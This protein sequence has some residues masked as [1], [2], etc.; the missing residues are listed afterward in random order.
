MPSSSL[1]T[2][3]QSLAPQV[4][5]KLQNL[6][7]PFVRNQGQLDSNVAFSA[8]T[9]GG[10]LYVTR[11]GALVLSLPV[12]EG[13]A[14]QP[15]VIRE[16]FMGARVKY[17][18][19]ETPLP[20]KVCYFHG[21]DP[22]KWRRNISTYSA[23]SLGEIYDGV[24]LKLRANA[25]NVEKLFCLR[26]GAKPENI[27]TQ[28]SGAFKT[29]ITSEGLLAMETKHGFVSFSKPVAY[30][31]VDGK[32]HFVNA[33]YRLTKDGYG[34]TI[35]EYDKN[36]ELII[37]PLIRASYLG[38]SYTEYGYNLAVHP[39]SGDVYVIGHTE[40]TDFPDTTGA[41]Q[42]S[43]GGNEDVYV[44]RFNADLTVL[45]QVSYLG[46]TGD[47][48]G[49]ALAFHSNTGDVYLTGSTNSTD[50]PSAV[51][52]N[53]GGRDM[54]IARLSEDL[55]TLQ[56]ALY[57]GTSHNDAGN[58]LV[59]RPD[60]ADPTSGELYIAGYYGRP[61]TGYPDAKVLRFN[62]E[63][64]IEMGDD[65]IGG[66]GN[67]IGYDLA[68]YSGDNPTDLSD[69][70]IYLVGYAGY[71]PSIPDLFV[72][73]FPVTPG[74][75]QTVFGGQED[76]FVARFNNDLTITEAATFLGAAGIDRG[77][78]IEVDTSGPSPTI[79]ITGYLSP[80]DPLPSNLLVFTGGAQ[81]TLAGQQDGFVARFNADLSSL[82]AGSYYG[83]SYHDRAW[84]LQ[85]GT[86]GDAYIAGVAQSN[87]LSGT[88]GGAQPGF[89]GGY[90]D[91]F[92]ARFS[93][94]LSSIEQA[95]Y[96]G[97]SAE[98]ESWWGMVIHPSN[99]DVY[100]AGETVSDD[101]SPTSGAP[102]ASRA[103]SWDGFVAAMD[104]D[105]KGEP[106]ADVS[107]D[108]SGP[109]SLALNDVL[110]Y[111]LTVSNN[112][113]DEATAVKVRDKL[114]EGVS[115]SEVSPGS[116]NVYGP[117][118]VLDQEFDSASLPPG[119]LE[120]H[121][122]VSDESHKAQTFTVDLSGTL[123]EIGVYIY[124]TSSEVSVPLLVDVRATDAQ[125][126]PVEDDNS[127]LA[128]AVVDAVDVPTTPGFLTV[129]ISAANLVVED[130]DLLAI[131]LR[132]NAQDPTTES[133][134]H[135]YGAGSNN[136]YSNGKHFVRTTTYPTWTALED[137]QATVPDTGFNSTVTTSY[138]VVEC[139]LGTLASG[140]STAVVI[141]GTGP[142]VD[143]YMTNEAAV[144]AAE[145]DPDM[146]NNEDSLTTMVGSPEPDIA[147]SPLTY[148]FGSVT[149]GDMTTPQTFTI[150]NNGNWELTV[151]SISNSNPSDFVM[152]VSGGGATCSS[153]IPFV[154][155]VG[156]SCDITVAFAPSMGGTRTANITIGSD[157]PDENPVV[158]T[159]TG[160]GIGEGDID[161]I[162]TSMS[163]PDTEVG[164][165]SELGIGISNTGTVDLTVT[166]IS[167]TEAASPTNF[168]LVVSGGNATCSASLPFTLTASASCILSVTFAPQSEGNHPA[169]VIITSDDPDEGTIYVPISGTGT[170]AGNGGDGG[171]TCFIAT[172]AR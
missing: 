75:A 69:D 48:L 152:V 113:P 170:A 27:R 34:F 61:G 145:F 93:A 89:G 9:S 5:T 21:K 70:K 10:T 141:D 60:P 43:L 148:D 4:Q 47:D 53:S 166:G 117:G 95:T 45:K 58:A 165:T 25:N 151:D 109:A 168:I 57:R 30:Q 154:L 159:L 49:L 88:V 23:V 161:V 51:N 7:I 111:N 2:S 19:G 81:E 44:A 162:P 68:I 136:L 22:A 129:D 36:K 131:V 73:D 65:D 76:V 103:G 97:G 120:L 163:F 137:T 101:L 38:G 17:V 32:Q 100:L 42:P 59:Y 85:L 125:G 171:G 140:A 142:G 110:T 39:V 134:Y 18:S 11:Q 80:Y 77:H 46:G 158:L 156:E 108:K 15:A 150:S 26:P 172:A 123:N 66:T 3:K 155:A 6:Q 157:D 74:A 115:V 143:Q 87:N 84:G 169:R 138:S 104:A 124:R 56:H 119:T 149:V 55:S 52:A 98:D 82:M 121:S 35:G 132:S 160:I 29:K 164:K 78:G 40:S 96:F 86:T 139:E 63:L 54:F 153:V 31:I 20:S 94:D 107:I 144:S 41:A 114:P 67:D 50:F 92:V 99:G 135:W 71:D 112:G 64:D 130:E 90:S 12:V 1:A 28:I 14:Q 91:A 79:Y 133:P 33:S 62:D 106:A 167:K 83:G 24:V 116:C 127:V 13:K 16:S 8:N 102:Y 128:S 126:V 72:S 118:P 37:D 147:L 146:G 122:I 105:L